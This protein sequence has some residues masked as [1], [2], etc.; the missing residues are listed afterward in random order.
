MTGGQERNRGTHMHPALKTGL[1]AEL[2][3]EETMRRALH[4]LMELSSGAKSELTPNERTEFVKD[5]TENAG[6]SF[7]RI[8]TIQGWAVS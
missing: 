5:A 4:G 2:L 3:P 7:D 6:S 1:K 8:R